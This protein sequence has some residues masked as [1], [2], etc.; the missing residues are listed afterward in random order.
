[1]SFESQLRDRCAIE[2]RSGDSVDGHGQPDGPF[3]AV[4]GFESVPCK[5][6][7]DS[8][9]NEIARVLAE[10]VPSQDLVYFMP[11]VDVRATDRIRMTL[12]NGQ[13]VNDELR[14]ER[15]DPCGGHH[16]KVS[17]IANT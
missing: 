11:G 6:T 17:V 14:I 1:M 7:V 10:G 5:R 8:R 15:L 3:V 12:W 2:R 13:V 9:S 16:W 4:A